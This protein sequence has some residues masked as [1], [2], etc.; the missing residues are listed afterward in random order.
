MGGGMPGQP[1]LDQPV[2]DPMTGQVVFPA[3]PGMNA[4]M[5]GDVNTITQIGDQPTQ[6]VVTQ[7]TKTPP[8]TKQSNLKKTLRFIKF[9]LDLEWEI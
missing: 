7:P 8:P 9:E 4:G 3:E 6:P 2:I 1:I 5:M